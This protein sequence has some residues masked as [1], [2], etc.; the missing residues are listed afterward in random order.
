MRKALK[1]VGFLVFVLILFVA[2]ASLAFYH[3]IEDGEFR[4]FLISEI[5]KQTEL[6]V[7][8]GDA[9][10][11]LGLILAVGCRGVALS[12]PGGTE[13]AI[14]AERITARVP[15]LSHLDGKVIF[16]ETGL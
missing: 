9:D 14:T 5:E 1:F 16:Y 3:L 8:L 12:E 4:R 10:L 11:E 2:V 13:R 15:L 6:K 7:Q